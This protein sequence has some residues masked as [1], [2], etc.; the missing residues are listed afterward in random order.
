MLLAAPGFRVGR[1]AAAAVQLI[2]EHK[3]KNYALAE[4][5]FRHDTAEWDSYC[6]EPTENYKWSLLM[7]A[8]SHMFEFVV[9]AILRESYRF[10]LDYTNVLGGNMYTKCLQLELTADKSMP[11]RRIIHS[12]RHARREMIAV[13]KER[14]DIQNLF[15][16]Y[17]LPAYE[18][19]IIS[20]FLEAPRTEF[21]LCDLFSDT[22]ID[23]IASMIA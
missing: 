2:L 12:I 21:L 1:W 4:T 3:D 6:W 7:V 19:S 18:R 10:D 20:E 5:V 22:L 13:R 23:L 9:L 17:R 16:E 8:I 14:S 15:L 11:C